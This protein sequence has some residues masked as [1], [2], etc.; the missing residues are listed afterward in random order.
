MELVII[1]III[2]ILI[3]II[4]TILTIIIITI[5]IMIMIMIMILVMIM[6]MMMIIID[7]F[8]VPPQASAGMTPKKPPRTRGTDPPTCAS[9]TTTR[10]VVFQ[11]Q[12]VWER[13]TIISCTL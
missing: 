9:G 2:I 3:L 4:I 10:N 8:L 7:V 11:I 12:S 6:I 5:T 1:I 13:S